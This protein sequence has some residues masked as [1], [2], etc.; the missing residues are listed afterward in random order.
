MM[1]GMALVAWILVGSALDRTPVK[2]LLIM[3]A[4][5]VILTAAAV[6]KGGA[7]EYG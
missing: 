5:A 6:L 3:F 1:E 7:Y 4:V 2:V